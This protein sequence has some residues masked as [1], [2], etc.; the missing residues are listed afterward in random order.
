V[1]P[2]ALVDFFP[3]SQ[4]K[5]VPHLKALSAIVKKKPGKTAINLRHL[6]ID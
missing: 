3:L 6:R 4:R 5:M 1:Q 2:K